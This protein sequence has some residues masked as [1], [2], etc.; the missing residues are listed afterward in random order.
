MYLT[1]NC[2]TIYCD[3]DTYY[4]IFNDRFK[5]LN[6]N[7]LVVGYDAN[8][9]FDSK[10][11]IAVGFHYGENVP[12]VLWMKNFTEDSKQSVNLMI[13]ISASYI[14]F[15]D[16]LKFGTPMHEMSAESRGGSIRY[17]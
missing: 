12:I 11:A 1:C 7:F 13:A 5:G 3:C 9:F 4:D 14:V 6:G 17:E 15:D 10:N 8:K 2:D 16:D